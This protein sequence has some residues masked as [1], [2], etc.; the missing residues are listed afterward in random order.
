M[1]S[2]LSCGVLHRVTFVHLA[3][4]L[5]A[6]GVIGNS[7]SF[8]VLHMYSS[9]NVGAYLLKALAV[10]DNIF[11][12]TTLGRP[13]VASMLCT[14]NTVRLEILIMAGAVCGVNIPIFF[15]YQGIL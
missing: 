5:C 2:T 11:L 3:G 15:I 1:S 13:Q 4:T 14:L 7:L 12:A 6:F 9:G 10:T 8:A